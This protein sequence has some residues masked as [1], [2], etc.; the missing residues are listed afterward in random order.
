MYKQ[1]AT[2]DCAP[3]LNIVRE[4]T[5]AW[6]MIPDPSPCGLPRKKTQPVDDR[7][8]CPVVAGNLSHRNSRERAP[9]STTSCHECGLRTFIPNYPHLSGR[10]ANSSANKLPNSRRANSLAGPRPSIA[11]NLLDF[12]K[13]TTLV[14]RSCTQ[15]HPR[16]HQIHLTVYHSP[17]THKKNARSHTHTNNTT[18]QK[19]SGD[20]QPSP[21]RPNPN[22]SVRAP[23]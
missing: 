21:S 23:K 7:P 1:R 22:P 16:T 19:A 3:I 11:L 8:R 14:I 17:Y 10:G 9:T 15:H 2:P 13:I 18:R 6:G 4:S 20:V 12:F 5:D